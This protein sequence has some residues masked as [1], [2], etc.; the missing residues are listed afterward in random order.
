MSL[1]DD[2]VS[3][4]T[5]TRSTLAIYS[6]DQ[7][8]APKDAAAVILLRHNTDPNNPEIFWVKR[9]TK[10]AFLGGFYAFPGGQKETNDGEAPV[11]NC[12]DQE[13][14]TMINCAARELFEEAGILLARGSETL[15]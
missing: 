1:N 7:S 2:S 9:S 3:R 15:T 4:K 6:T 11:E 8:N 13:L 5:S 14:A 12:E 10:L